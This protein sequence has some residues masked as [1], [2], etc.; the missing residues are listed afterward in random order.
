[1]SSFPPVKTVSLPIFASKFPC[2]AISSE[3]SCFVAP[4]I[5]TKIYLFPERSSVFLMSISDNP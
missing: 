5:S 2:E 1:M 4:A 3:T